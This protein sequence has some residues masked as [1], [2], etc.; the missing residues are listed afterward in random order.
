M[1]HFNSSILTAQSVISLIQNNRVLQEVTIIVDLWRNTASQQGFC[2]SNQEAKAVYIITEDRITTNIIVY[3]KE[4]KND[5]LTFQTESHDF[6]RD[7]DKAAEW[8]A[9]DI[10]H[11]FPRR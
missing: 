7:F 5:P 8:L 1:L 11:T 6:D 3:K 2:L 4:E 9:K 10:F